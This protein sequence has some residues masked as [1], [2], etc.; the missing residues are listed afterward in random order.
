[1]ARGFFFDLDAKLAGSKWHAAVADFWV[2]QH[3]AAG[4][5]PVGGRDGVG[6]DSAELEPPGDAELLAKEEV[7]G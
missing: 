4:P 5:I 7:L 2:R 6:F 1:M 3:I